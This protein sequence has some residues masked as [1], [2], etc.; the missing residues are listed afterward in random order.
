[1]A[2]GKTD[3]KVYTNGSECFS[4][5]SLRKALWNGQWDRQTF[6]SYP[7]T[8]SSRLRLRFGANTDGII[9]HEIQV[10]NTFKTDTDIVTVYDT[11]KTKWST[12]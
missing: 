8:F 12:V 5:S 1:M 11:L 6:A 2:Q 4:G 9:L 3:C 10:H 7:A